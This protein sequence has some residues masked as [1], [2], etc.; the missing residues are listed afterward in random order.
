ME[1]ISITVYTIDELREQYPE[2]Y[3]KAHDRYADDSPWFI[4]SINDALQMCADE[5]RSPLAGR[6]IEWDVYRGYAHYSDGDLTPTE[7]GAMNEMFPG[8]EG[9]TGLYL[10]GGTLHGSH[11]GDDTDEARTVDALEGADEWLRDLHAEFALRMR[12]EWEYLMSDEHFI[13]S[14]EANE[15]TFEADGKM[16]NV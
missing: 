16:R 5:H 9:A 8:L 10:S 2:A 7:R 6:F 15:W 3:R 11:Y 14:C 1:T 12:S 4:E 13:E